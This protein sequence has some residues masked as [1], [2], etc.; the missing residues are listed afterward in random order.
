MLD[1]VLAPTRQGTQERQLQPLWQAGREALHIQLRCVPPLRLQ[2]HLQRPNLLL[3]F[4]LSPSVSAQHILSYQSVEWLMPQGELPSAA[5]L[6]QV[7][8]SAF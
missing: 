3:T 2:K 5:Q 4:T 8:A 6:I 7:H 1:T